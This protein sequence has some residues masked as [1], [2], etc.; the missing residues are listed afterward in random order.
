M[1]CRVEEIIDK[2]VWDGF[3]LSQKPQSFLQ[4][5]NWGET[6]RLVGHKIFRLGIFDGD[7]LQGVC[8]AI[9]EEARRGPHLVVPGGPIVNWGELGIVREVIDILAS[10]ARSEKVWFVRVRPELLDNSEAKRLF[11]RLNFVPAPMHLHAEN[12]WV[13]NIDRS[14]EEILA[15]MRKTTRYLVRQSLKMGLVVEQYTDP[16]DVKVLTRLQEETVRRHKFVPFSE[17]LFGAQLETFGKDGEGSLFVCK[18]GEEEVAAAII[19][20]YGDIAYYHHSGST[21]NYRNLPFSYF[22]QWNIIQ[23]ARKRGCK[24]Y[25]F[26]GI[27]PTDDLKHRFAGV[28]V[29]KKGFGGERIDWLHAQDLP[30]SPLYW[31][32]YGFETTRK[33][34]RR[35]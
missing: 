24:F 19:I 8:L 14:E 23:E 34:M 28:T 17:K 6:Q 10:L 25:N 9:L 27:A 18:K 16:A 20:F 33:V 15:G 21:S 1:K 7:S 13:L 22:L 26:W 3:V 5:W 12:T 35:L 31:L 2:E 4:S 32:T 29:F 11:S 30:I